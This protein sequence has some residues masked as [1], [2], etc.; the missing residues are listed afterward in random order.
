MSYSYYKPLD[1]VQ[2]SDFRNKYTVW[3]E[4]GIHRNFIYVYNNERDTNEAKRWRCSTVICNPALKTIYEWNGWNQFA[5]NRM[6][7]KINKNRIKLLNNTSEIEGKKYDDIA[8]WNYAKK[9]VHNFNQKEKSFSLA[10]GKIMDMVKGVLEAQIGDLTSISKILSGL[11][12][13]LNSSKINL[14]NIQGDC[15]KDEDKTGRDVYFIIKY[16]IDVKRESYGFWPLAH[17][18][19]SDINLELDIRTLS[20]EN[21]KATKYCELLMNQKI[22]DMILS[23]VVEQCDEIKELNF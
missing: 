2:L 3:T 9:T 16:N 18:H 17:G 22:E 1:E 13:T 23:D 12:V 8:K 10:V 4:E 5:L 11:N 7:R 20:P 15:I 14:K 21:I 19:T 6:I